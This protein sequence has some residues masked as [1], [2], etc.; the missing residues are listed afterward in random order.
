MTPILSTRSRQR[1][2]ITGLM[3]GRV[4]FNNDYDFVQDTPVYVKARD[5]QTRFQSQIFTQRQ[6]EKRKRSSI[7]SNQLADQ[8]LYQSWWI[9]P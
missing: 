4:S 7:G 3:K 5:L 2:R 1:P 6:P 8:A 9:S